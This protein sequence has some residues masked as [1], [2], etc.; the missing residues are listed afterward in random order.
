VQ[1]L[2]A[3]LPGHLAWGIGHLAYAPAW[4]RLVWPILGL[5]LLWRWGA[6]TGLLRSLGRFLESPFSA[7]VLVLL[8]P[9]LF[10]I[11]RTR[12]YFLG[13][14]YLV[15]ELLD[16][17]LV[18]RTYDGLDFYG[19]ALLLKLLGG[20]G[21]VSAFRLH[22]VTSVV[23]GAAYLLVARWASLRLET[24]AGW[25]GLL[26]ALLVLGGSLELFF[27]YVESYAFQTVAIL[28]FLAAGVLAARGRFPMWGVGLLFGLGVSVHTTTI[29]FLPALIVLGW[30][31]GRERW[32]RLAELLGASLV[33]VL[34]AV[35]AMLAG[36]YGWENFQKDV[37]GSEHTRSIFMPLV[38]EHGILSPAHVKD[39][40]NLLLLLVPVPLVMIALGCGRLG[41]L[42]RKDEGR[43][44]LVGAATLLF[45]VL[46]LDRKLGEAR[47]WDLLAGHATVFAL[48]ALA[49]WK[50]GTA[51]ETA[52]GK[53]GPS[54]AAGP[55]RGIPAGTQALVLAAFFLALPWYWVHADAE[56]GLRR[57]REIIA[58]F[59]DF[60][61]AYAHEEMAKYY[62]NAKRYEEALREYETCVATFPGNPRFRTLLGSM[63]AARGDLEGAM[64][65][66]EAAL[67]IEANYEPALLMMIQAYQIQGRTRETLPLF[68]RL[69]KKRPEDPALWR[70]YGAAN[71]LV[72][73][74][75]SALVAYRRCLALD[76]RVQY[77]L[78]YGVL[79]G[80]ARR[81]D[82][83]KRIFRS[84]ERHPEAGDRARLGLA[85][86]LVL[87][88]QKD[89][90]L[91]AEELR[92][93]LERARQLLRD[94]LRRHPNT[95]DALSA[96]KD[97]EE[98]LEALER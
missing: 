65:E 19:H 61:R 29:F 59:A 1:G 67:E 95:P 53:K 31:R 38:G 40:A 78:E 77:Q 20:P 79:A 24:E 5:V 97:V 57:F 12:T 71:Q 81:W 43:F 46:T 28:L 10:W 11:L 36:G 50:Q 2:A 48:L 33:V 25:R 35:G 54:S 89:S 9:A 83:A 30:R 42:W 32:R 63:R 51:R 6:R 44:L 64:E 90:S 17:G 68:R 16:R 72:G 22:A 88:A 55:A 75:D 52:A 15:G 74:L 58:D 60:P 45:L 34:A 94:Y 91:T 4:L 62:R 87:Q 37:I 7:S 21:S 93:N 86:T 41:S 96:L 66:Y 69:L 49:V 47:D 56:R 18:F 98:R 73:E 80:L 76:Q 82:E 26:F 85:T 92:G 3:W 27:G 23:A 8:G 39:V 84:L 13:D 70:N 14:G